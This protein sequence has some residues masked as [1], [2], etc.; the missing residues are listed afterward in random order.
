MAT[1]PIST[2]LRMLLAFALVLLTATSRTFAAGAEET[3]FPVTA[4]PLASIAFFVDRHLGNELKDTLADAARRLSDSRCQQVL[5][6]FTDGSGRPLAENL[7]AIGQSF[8]GY[9]GLVLFY[10]GTSTE[11]CDGGRVLAWTTPGNRAVHVCRERFARWRRVN[12]GYAADIVIHEALH[13]LGLRE[14]PP[15]PGAITAKVIERCG[16]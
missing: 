8:P 7:R 14:S 12:P 5:D 9:L 10:D 2:K 15:S 11:A 4:A 16:P 6:D 13:T 1:T 3:N